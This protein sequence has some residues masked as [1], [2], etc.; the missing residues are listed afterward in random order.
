MDL[1]EDDG[2]EIRPYDM[3]GPRVQLLARAS[4]PS[5]QMFIELQAN[6]YLDIFE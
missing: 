3:N 5:K 6:K 4:A 2:P 1:I